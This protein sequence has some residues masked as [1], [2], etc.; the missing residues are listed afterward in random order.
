M[1]VK[2]GKNTCHPKCF[3]RNQADRNDNKMAASVVREAARFVFTD[4]RTVL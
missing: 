2:A 4:L 1:E 3:S